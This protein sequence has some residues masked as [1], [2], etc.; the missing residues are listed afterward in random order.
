MDNGL[1]KLN[2]ARKYGQV[3]VAI[4]NDPD[5]RALPPAAQHLYLLLWTSP[6]LSFCGV[7]E[8]RPGR[9]TKLSNGFAEEHTRLVAA[10]LQARH[11]LVIDEETEEVLIR[12][13][14]RFDELLKQ[15]RLAVSYSS[16]YAATYS[17]T[18]RQVL[19][20]ET[21]K[22][23]KL[24]PE[25]PCWKD[26]RVSVILEHPAVSAKDLP[27][28]ED[29][30]GDGFGGAFGPGFALGLAQTSINVWPPGY[31]PPTPA[32]TPTPNKLVG[33][34]KSGT[35]AKKATSLPSDWAP[36][37]KH[38]ELAAELGVDLTSELAKFR[39]HAIANGKTFK[40]WDAGFRTWLRNA[41]TFGGGRVTRLPTQPDNG[42][43]RREMP[44]PPPEIA[45]DP[46]R[47]ARWLA[48]RS[49]R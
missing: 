39:D 40:D 12:S 41:V 34:D 35:R 36:S 17:P 10:S 47:Y 23:Q 24:W 25:L 8:W 5:F 22:M 16:A 30:F 4:W 28:P 32:P 14:A 49:G 43:G 31:P 1:E 11:F 46:E 13:W 33:P 27:T 38:Q 18:L 15:P 9:L 19:A 20:R 21:T 7:H 42:W 45:D 6:H 2:V 48:E 26:S 37:Q 44:V 3:N 29:P